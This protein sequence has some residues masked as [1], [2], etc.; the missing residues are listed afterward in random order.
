[1]QAPGFLPPLPDVE[2]MACDQENLLKF[3]EEGRFSKIPQVPLGTSGMR[4]SPAKKID[5]S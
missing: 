1:M 4:M 3:P 2:K 5:A